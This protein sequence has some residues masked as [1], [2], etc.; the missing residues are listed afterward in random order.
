MLG[1]RHKMHLLLDLDGTLVDSDLLHERAFRHVLTSRAPEFLTR[2]QYEAMKGLNTR[3]VFRALGFPD[4]DHLTAL[5]QEKQAQY[6]AAV[7]AGALRL[8]PGARALLAQLRKQGRSAYLVTSSSQGSVEAALRATG[9]ADFFI[10][11][12]TSAD[13]KNNKPA[14]DI[15]LCCLERYALCRRDCLV[16]EDACSGLV[17][18]QRA[19]L[20]VVVVNN[21]R[22]DLQA[23]HSYPTLA[24]FLHAVQQEFAEVG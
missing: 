17:S 14:P 12:V 7:A 22:R 19:G 3:D 4:D 15:Y 23:I 1:L 13:V 9:I 21:P 2:F 8:F 24:D 20:D 5:V 16:V 11:I 6:R 18:G 10:G